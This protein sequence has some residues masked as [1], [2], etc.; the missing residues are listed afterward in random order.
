VT[1]SLIANNSASGNGGIVILPTGS[2]NVNFV[3][4]RIRVENNPVAGIWVQGNLSS[5]VIK[6]FIRDTV[7]TGSTVLGGSLPCEYRSLG[8]SHPRGGQ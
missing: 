3:L 7:V 1:D 8:L 6:D 4:D 5:G 2:A